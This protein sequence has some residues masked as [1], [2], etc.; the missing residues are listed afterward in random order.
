MNWYE[1]QA[2][3]GIP[4]W[5]LVGI[6]VVIPVVFVTVAYSLDRLLLWIAGW[7]A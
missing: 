5:E 4:L 2:E 6:A 1:P 3:R 7:F